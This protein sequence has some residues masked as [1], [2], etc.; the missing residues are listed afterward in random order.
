MGQ[1]SHLRQPEVSGPGDGKGAQPGSP[2]AEIGS[3]SGSRWPKTAVGTVA[4]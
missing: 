4:I 1:N 2:A 3:A